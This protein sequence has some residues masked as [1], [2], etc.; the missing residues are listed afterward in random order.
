MNTLEGNTTLVPTELDMREEDEEDTY[1]VPE[2]NEVEVKV[3]I[4][5]DKATKS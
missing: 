5:V 1:N 3:H 4:G 2:A